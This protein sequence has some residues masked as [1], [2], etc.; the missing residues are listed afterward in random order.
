MV[1]AIKI[2]ISFSKFMIPIDLFE[3]FISFSFITG[4]ESIVCRRLNVE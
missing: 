4:I 1:C 2:L 3:K